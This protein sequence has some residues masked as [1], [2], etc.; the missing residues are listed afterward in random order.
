MKKL[1]T[2][3]LALAALTIFISCGDDQPFGENELVIGE[4][5]MPLIG[6]YYWDS[7]YDLTNGFDRR[8]EVEVTHTHVR[9]RVVFYDSESNYDAY[10][11][12]EFYSKGETFKNGKF[13]VKT[14]SDD[15]D[16]NTESFVIINCDTYNEGYSFAGFDGKSGTI[17]ISSD[18][19]EV[20]PN[21]MTIKFNF[22]ATTSVP[23]S[24]R[25]QLAEN[26]I[27]ITGQFKGDIILD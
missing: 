7:Q 14:Y 25:G 12:V 23:V 18:V 26:E 10:F 17:S 1:L 27:E 8:T 16:A 9:R 4:E 19:D 5:V 21:S 20:N 22:I 11:S 13:T 3:T 6:S 24:V 2:L 15:V